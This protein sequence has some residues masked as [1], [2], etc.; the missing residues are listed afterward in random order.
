M[1]KLYRGRKGSFKGNIGLDMD[2][3]I[4]VDIEVQGSWGFKFAFHSL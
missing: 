1:M 4:E 2:V 3:D